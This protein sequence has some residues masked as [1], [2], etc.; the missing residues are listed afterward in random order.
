[1][2]R[3]EKVKNWGVEVENE[4]RL[5]KL[6]KIIL[7]VLLITSVLTIVLSIVREDWILLVV[8][9]LSIPLNFISY[10]LVKV[11]VEISLSNKIIIYN[12]LQDENTSKLK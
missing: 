4:K 7:I 3:L 9:L 1:M 6:T 11:I 8:S 12:S 10:F 5:T 2:E